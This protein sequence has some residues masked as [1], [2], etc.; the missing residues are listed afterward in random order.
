MSVLLPP[1][2]FITDKEFS[3]IDRVVYFLIK[4]LIFWT[5]LE[6]IFIMVSYGSYIKTGV[7]EFYEITQD[8]VQTI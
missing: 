8:R 4:V 7:G 1:T 2:D 6:L 3:L 5:L